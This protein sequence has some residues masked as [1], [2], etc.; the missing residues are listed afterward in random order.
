MTLEPEAG[1][2]LA[3]KCNCINCIN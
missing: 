3:E 1:L 2:Y